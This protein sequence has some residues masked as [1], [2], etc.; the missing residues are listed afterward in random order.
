MNRLAMHPPPKRISSSRFSAGN[1]PV[2][3]IIH[4]RRRPVCR[5]APK[6]TLHNA[7]RE[8]SRS[9]LYSYIYKDEDCFV[10]D[11]SSTACLIP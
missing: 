10:D 6:W 8:H 5:R 11:V 3:G 7:Q 2:L 1:I 9:T 4:N